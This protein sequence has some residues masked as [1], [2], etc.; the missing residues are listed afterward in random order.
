[1]L[2]ISSGSSYLGFTKPYKCSNC[3]NVGMMSVKQTYV[4][5]SLFLIPIANVNNNVYA[6]CSTCE[7]AFDLFKRQLIG[8]D[9][10]KQELLEIM[11]GGKEAFKIFLNEID[12]KSREDILKRL[13]KLGA[14]DLVKY[15]CC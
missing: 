11:D 2:A 7:V 10:R 5:Q 4:K 13:N 14:Y 15:Y 8:E 12:H 1:M 6:Q 9:K 3:N